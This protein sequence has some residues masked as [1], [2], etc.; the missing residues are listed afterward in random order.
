MVRLLKPEGKRGVTTLFFSVR[1]FTCSLVSFF[2]RDEA[3]VWSGS[4]T[5]RTGIMVDM[6]TVVMLLGD[7][8]DDK[9][10]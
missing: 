9:L 4:V 1:T 5:S 3:I 7:D 10:K 2:Y 8:D 6:T